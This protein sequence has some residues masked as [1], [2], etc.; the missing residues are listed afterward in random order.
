MIKEVRTR[1]APSPTGYMH[2]GNLRTAIFEYLIA[3]VNNGKFILRIEDTDQK[4]FV[5]GATELMYK[6]LKQ[7]GIFHD[8]GPDVGGNYGPYIQS[9][10]KDLYIKYAEGLVAKGD[11]YYCFCTKERLETLKDD[12]GNMKYDRH[13]LS[14]SK[15]A[16]ETHLNN[17]DSFVIR[18]KMPTEGSTT[19]N[20]M[21]YGDITIDNKELEDQIMIKSDGFPTYNFAN[22][23]DDH[24]MEISHVVR[25][26]EYI[27]STPKYNLLYDALGWDKPTYVHVPLIIGDDGKKLSKRNGDA[28]FEDLI[29]EGY[30]SEAIVNYIAL[31]GWSPGNEREFFTMK[32]LEEAFN[33]NNIS[34]SPAVFDKNKL[35]WMNGEL[36]K[37]M[38]DEDFCVLVKPFLKKAIKIENIDLDKVARLLK[39]RTEVLNDD[40]IHK[41]A[42]LETLPDYDVEIYTHKKMKTDSA[43]SLTSL[44][45]AYK[46]LESLEDWT[47]LSIHDSLINLVGVLGIK[48]SQLLW[49][50]RTAIS[51]LQVSPGG[52]IEIAEILGK[53]ETLIRINVGIEK[54]EE[55]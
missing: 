9:Q 50:V 36:I 23:I 52:A 17:G 40:I 12:L 29:S 31:L 8:E 42:F 38:S 15:E 32:E 19:F 37:R 18:Q 45:E 34:K 35:T 22:V 30:I 7:A 33:Y 48:N 16:I 55:K 5:E 53:N 14:M 39:S 11:A 3:K 49:P 51:G 46:V 10:R 25:G 54:L 27:T 1:F 26:N 47:E 44:K 13:C 21:I 20:D 2:V 28:S 43:I 4:R 6:T 24:L 41:V